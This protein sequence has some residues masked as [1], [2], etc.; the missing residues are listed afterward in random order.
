MMNVLGLCSGHA[1][2]CFLLIITAVCSGCVTGPTY[3][4]T[5]VG[6]IDFWLQQ[7]GKTCNATI[8]IRNRSDIRK[9]PARIDL[10]WRSKDDLT[11]LET[12]VRMDPVRV[13]RYDAKNVQMT[14]LECVQIERVEIAAAEWAEYYPW[15][16]GE[17]VWRKIEGAAGT[18]W[19]FEWRSEQDLYV[20][21]G[22]DADG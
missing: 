9:G 14:E 7:A 19:T 10:I 21:I 4:T 16:E 3:T 6:E 2:K 8:G 18:S 12:S 1:R 15:R 17:Y 11:K 20:G 5:S 22:G 13:N